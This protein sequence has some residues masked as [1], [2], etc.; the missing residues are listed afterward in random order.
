M[1]SKTEIEASTTTRP[2]GACTDATLPVM[3]DGRPSA[4]RMWIGANAGLRVLIA[5]AVPLVRG[6]LRHFLAADPAI[7]IVGE[8]SDGIEAVRLG[9]AL[10]PDVVILDPALP[11]R[12]GLQ[13]IQELR[14]RLPET[15]FLVFSWKTSDGDVRA[16]LEAGASGYLLKDD[17][18]GRLPAIVRELE[19]SRPYLSSR[20]TGVLIQNYLG[21]GRPKRRTQLLTKRQTDI[22]WLI[23]AGHGSRDIGEQLGISLR[24]VHTHRYRIMRRL[25]VHTEG[26][27]IHAAVRM[28]LLNQQ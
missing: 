1:T 6:G 25:H 16:A 2:A 13:V 24:T 4:S 9:L 17:D 27:L 21:G 28:G 20:I 10:K 7:E 26:A 8:A 5:D 18:L 15:R 23:A 11:G 22:L 19:A 14:R 12:Y 3:V